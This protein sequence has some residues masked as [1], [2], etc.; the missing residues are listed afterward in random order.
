MILRIGQGLSENN[1]KN[2]KFYKLVRSSNDYN[3]ITPSC[4][5]YNENLNDE[6]IFLNKLCTKKIVTFISCIEARNSEDKCGISGKNFIQ[7]NVL[8]KNIEYPIIE[9]KLQ[10]LTVLHE[11]ARVQELARMQELAKISDKLEKLYLYSKSFNEEDN[12]NE[13]RRIILRDLFQISKSM[14]SLENESSIMGNRLD[15]EF[16]KYI[17]YIY[18][19][20]H[21]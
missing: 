13:I 12:E 20:S 15:N 1:C 16:I 2:C 9:D 11:L 17:N 10:L 8:K 21:Y 5:A 3:I 19:T 4:I 14:N 18:T 7:F 6:T